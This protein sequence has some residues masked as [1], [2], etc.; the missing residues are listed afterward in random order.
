[1]L[2][3]DFRNLVNQLQSVHRDNLVSVVLYGSAIEAPGN[4]RKSDYEVLVVARRFSVDDLRRTRPV[5]QNWVESGYAMP[6]LFTTDELKHALD[7]YP[8]EFTQMKRAYRVLSGEDLLA[9]VEISSANLR[10]ETEHELR[11]KL[12]RLRSLY[13]P[14]SA[15][16]SDLTNLMTESIVSFVKLMRPVLTLLGE[17]PPLGRLATIQRIGERLGMETGPLVSILQLRSEP[18]ELLELEAQDL[19]TGYL[20]CLD[21]IIAAV[22]KM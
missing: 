1:M 8:I 21:H 12:L 5:V 15:S 9:G 19:F 11:G 13:L 6:V 10:W 4:P 20:D 22:D 16:T 18:R 17:H 2:D 7:V 3:E 14:A